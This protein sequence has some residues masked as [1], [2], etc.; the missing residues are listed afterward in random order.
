MSVVLTKTTRMT[1]L[2]LERAFT[3]EGSSAGRVASEIFE[4]ELGIV[5]CTKSRQSNRLR[6]ILSLHAYGGWGLQRFK[7][8]C[9]ASKQ[10]IHVSRKEFIHQDSMMVCV[11]VER[12]K[13]G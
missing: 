13:P 5:S 8:R 9:T 11:N 4:F 12:G 6:H 2:T 7:D 3:A 1:L 10:Q